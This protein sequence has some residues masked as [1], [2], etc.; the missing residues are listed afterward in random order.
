[1]SFE[2]QGKE[3]P[4][5][6]EFVKRIYEAGKKQQAVKIM[7]VEDEKGNIHSVAFL[8]WDEEAV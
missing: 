6:F 8:V 7:A 3:I 4:Y 5:S 1:M 2:R